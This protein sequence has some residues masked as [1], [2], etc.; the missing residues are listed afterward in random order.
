MQ[1]DSSFYHGNGGSTTDEPSGHHP[2]PFLHTLFWC[3]RPV[4]LRYTIFLLLCL[5]AAHDVVLHYPYL[6]TH[7]FM[8]TYP[9][10]SVVC[11]QSM[12]FHRAV[13]RSLWFFCIQGRSTRFRKLLPIRS[14]GLVVLSVASAFFYFRIETLERSNCTSIMCSPY[15]LRSSLHNLVAH[16][17]VVHIPYH[18]IHTQFMLKCPYGSVL[19]TRSR[20]FHRATIWYLCIFTFGVEVTLFRKLL[21]IQSPGLVRVACAII[22]QLKHLTGRSVHLLCM[23]LTFF[24]LICWK[25]Q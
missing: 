9:Y 19:C 21:P 24:D 10:A 13:I 1:F 11:V 18:P 8:S 5:F 23:S 3:P 17:L 16:D 4:S 22:L 14:A 20:W 7:N 25:H 6:A 15:L 12:W 2:L